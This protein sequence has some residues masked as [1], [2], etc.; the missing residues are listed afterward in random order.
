MSKG[1]KLLNFEEKSWG[2]HFLPE[3]PWA[4]PC[5]YS[6]YWHVIATSSYGFYTGGVGL[7]RNIKQTESRNLFWL[8]F[9]VNH[10]LIPTNRDWNLIKSVVET[11]IVDCQWSWNLEVQHMKQIG[12]FYI[13]MISFHIIQTIR[14]DCCFVLLT[15]HNKYT[16]V[17]QKKSI[18][19]QSETSYV[20]MVLEVQNTFY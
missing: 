8:S 2:R 15:E 12:C 7:E 20:N 6:L 14:I 17:T 5:Y 3:N 18:A 9:G 16:Y 4:G 13:Y 1:I 11:V 10:L 19:G